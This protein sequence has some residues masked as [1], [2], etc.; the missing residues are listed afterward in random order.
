M[1]L[2]G[3]SLPG[4]VLS[5][6]STVNDVQGSSV[7]NP[8]WPNFLIVGAM[9]CGTTYLWAHLRKHPQVFLPDLKEPNFFQTSLPDPKTARH[10]NYE[11]CIGNQEKYLAL[12]RNARGYTAI[13]DASPTYLWDVNAPRR[14]RE[15]IPKARIIIVLR[16]PIARAQ[17]HYLMNVRNGL[18]R[19]RTFERAVEHDVTN[20]GIGFFGRHLYVEMGLYYQPVQRYIDTFGREQ[21][22]VLLLDDLNKDFVGTMLQV[23]QHLGINPSMQTDDERGEPINVYKMPRFPRTY[24]FMTQLFSRRMREQIFPSF[25]ETWLGNTL[26]FYDRKKPVV[27]LDLRR[28]LQELYEPDIARL[29][30]LLGR[31]LPELRKSWT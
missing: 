5:T 18:E 10:L 27:D 6:S 11:Y 8:I 17:S 29:E 22:L 9:K 4:R 28:R 15:V 20:R 25:I 13:G 21:V 3:L 14:I 19:H 7:E 30:N 31:K 12:F 24:R 23:T 2:Q 16:D 26:L 1:L